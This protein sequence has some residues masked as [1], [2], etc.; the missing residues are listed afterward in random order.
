[1]YE[2]YVKDGILTL[3]YINYLFFSA[4]KQSIRDAVV[5]G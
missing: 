1:M 5:C 4:L 3:K 2:L